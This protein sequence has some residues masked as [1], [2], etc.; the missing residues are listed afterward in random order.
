MTERAAKDSGGTLD[1]FGGW[2]RRLSE[3]RGDRSRSDA[4]HA[5][6]IDELEVGEIDAHVERDAVIRDP[7]FDTEAE[8]ADL[9]RVDAIGIA[10]AA[11]VAVPPR[12]VDA[13]CGARRHEGRLE[14]ADKRP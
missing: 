7:A 6:G 5:A 2:L 9:A 1:R 14:G 12:C 4:G 13:V 10:P 3:L 11:R 8:G